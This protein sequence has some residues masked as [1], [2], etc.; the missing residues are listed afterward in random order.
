MNQ[1][2][3]LLL[4]L[5]SQNVTVISVMTLDLTCTGKAESLLC[6]GVS[7]YFWHFFVN[8]KLLFIICGNAYTK[9]LRT[10]IMLSSYC[11]FLAFESLE[12]LSAYFCVS[13]KSAVC[14]HLPA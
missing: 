13:K 7:L 1:I 14:R 5:L 11:L 8:L 6:T 2:S 3:L 9:A 10:F 4:C 12:S